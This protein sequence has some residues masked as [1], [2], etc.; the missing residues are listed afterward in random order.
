MVRRPPRSTRTD[1]LSPYTTLFRSRFAF[2]FGHG[3]GGGREDHGMMHGDLYEL[4]LRHRFRLLPGGEGDA[5]GFVVGAA[6]EGERQEHGRADQAQTGNGR[7]GH[8]DVTYSITK[9]TGPTRPPAFALGPDRK[10][11]RLNSSH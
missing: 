9:P 5:P 11:T 3:A 4:R 2:G 7:C 8:H 1:T 6:A 10:S